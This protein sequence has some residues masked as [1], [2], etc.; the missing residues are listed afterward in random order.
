MSAFGIH[1]SAESWATITNNVIHASGS[2]GI[3]G[4]SG[5][6]VSGNTVLS[7]GG[8]GIRANGSVESNVVGRSGGSGIVAPEA[9]HNTVYLNGGSGLQLSGAESSNNISYGNGGYGLLWTGT[10][11]PLV[12]CNDWYG[13][14]QGATSG[15]SAGASD[16]T[17][18]PLFCNLPADNVSLASTSALLA[19]AECGL[20]GALGQGCTVA[21]GVPAAAGEARRFTVQPNPA[22]GG[23]D[24]RWEPS[25]VPSSVDVFDVAGRLRYHA[26]VPAGVGALGWSGGDAGDHAL[27]GGL[28]FVRRVSGPTQEHTR[29]VL[30]R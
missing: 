24:F 8:D 11:T 25:S 14:I 12:S 5:W 19:P 26:D 22:R 1:A 15:V 10:G 18:N 7:A 2:H 29:V 9:R 4:G 17:V 3:W 16:L 27:P 30:A 23:V 6:T 28:Y 13:N 20:I 21:A